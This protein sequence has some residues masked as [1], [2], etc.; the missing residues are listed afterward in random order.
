MR[1]TVSCME[2]IEAGRVEPA[3]PGPTDPGLEVRAQRVAAP[4]LARHTITLADGHRV[5]LAVSGKGVPLVV[6]HGYSAEG[7]LYAQTLSRL[8]GMGFKVVAVDTAGH[9][10]TRGLPQ[11]GA[12]LSSYTELLC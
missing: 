1:H 12:R 6:V 5:G 9:G 8:V 11:N 3:A 2:G 7:F 4:R 10:S